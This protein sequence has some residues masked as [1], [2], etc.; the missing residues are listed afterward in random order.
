[1][2]FQQSKHVDWINPSF[3]HWRAE[4]YTYTYNMSSLKI[5]MTDSFLRSH[6]DY[7]QNTLLVPEELSSMLRSVKPST[8]LHRKVRD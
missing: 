1:M 2:S 6:Q 8:Q 7:Q 4:F 5:R 3:G